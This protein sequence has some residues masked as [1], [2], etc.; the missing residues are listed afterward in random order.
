MEAPTLLEAKPLELGV[1]CGEGA[2]A[3]PE[4]KRV[5]PQRTIPRQQISRQPVPEVH[6]RMKATAAKLQKAQQ[7]VQNLPD[8]PKLPVNWQKKRPD[9][10]TK[11]LVALFGAFRAGKSSFANALLG[12]KSSAGFTQSDDSGHQ[13]NQTGCC[14]PCMERCSSKLKTEQA[15]LD[16]V[17][18]ALQ[19]F[20]LTAADLNDARQKWQELQR[21]GE[22]SGDSGQTNYS[23]LQAFSRGYAALGGRLDMVIETALAEFGAYVAQEEKSCFVEWIDLYYDCPLTRKGITLVDTPGGGF[24]QCPSYGRR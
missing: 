3:R 19:V 10:R 14:S 1:I 20:G 4:K 24:D 17:K 6:D 16:D 9:W 5:R 7:L 2:S 15:M 18:Q 22:T 13:Q 21:S 12:E 11:G 23:F 8:L